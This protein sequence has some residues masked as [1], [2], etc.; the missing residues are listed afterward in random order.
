M[1][2]LSFHSKESI[3]SNDFLVDWSFLSLTNMWVMA[4]DIWLRDSDDPLPHS[5]VFCF[6]DASW[7]IFGSCSPKCRSWPSVELTALLVVGETPK[8]WRSTSLESLLILPPT[9]CHNDFQ[10]GTRK[11]PLMCLRRERPPHLKPLLPIRPSWLTLELRT[12]PAEEWTLSLS[13]CSKY[14]SY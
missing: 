12:Q 10:Q 2:S 14:S 11:G 3:V 4:F 7:S 8:S 13:W 1:P 5:C 9:M 6:R